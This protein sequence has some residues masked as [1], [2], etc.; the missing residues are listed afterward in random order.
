LLSLSFVLPYPNV[1]PIPFKAR[2]GNVQKQVK[3]VQKPDACHRQRHF[4]RWMLE[5][6]AAFDASWLPGVLL[7]CVLQLIGMITN[8]FPAR[9]ED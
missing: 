4:S 2:Q 1:G 7:T 3:A 5:N 8:Q 6:F 9:L